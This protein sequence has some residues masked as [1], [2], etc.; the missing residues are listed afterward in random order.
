M[1]SLVV[2]IVIIV[3]LLLFWF[4]FWCHSGHVVGLYCDSLFLLDSAVIYC[5]DGGVVGLMS[6]VSINQ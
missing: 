1:N 5:A 2:V 6:I 3:L 4:W